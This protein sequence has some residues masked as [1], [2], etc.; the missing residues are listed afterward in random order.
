ML[1]IVTVIMAIIITNNNRKEKN[2]ENLKIPKTI[3][4]QGDEKSPLY[5]VCNGKKWVLGS[6]FR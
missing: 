4:N 6:I 3:N 5:C 2:L 1:Q